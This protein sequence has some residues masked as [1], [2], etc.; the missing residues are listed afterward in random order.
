MFGLRT[1]CSCE[2]MQ[3]CDPIRRDAPTVFRDRQSIGQGPAQRPSG[4]RRL[5][6]IIPTIN[7]EGTIGHTLERVRCGRV[8]EVIVVDGRST[9]RTREIARAHGATVVESSPGRGRQLAAG[10]TIATGDTLLFLHADT[11]L[12]SGFDDHVF[13]A[14]EKRGVCAAAFRLL[15][16]GEGQ[17][18]RLIDRMVNF[19]SSV[20]QMPYGDQ[21]IFVRANALRE[22][23]GFPDLPVMEDYVLIRR[24][25][26]I[27]RIE[28][29]P[30]TVVTSARRWI[31]QGVLR[32]T[33]FNQVCIAA[34]WLGVSPAR[35]ARWR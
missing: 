17:C 29:V 5:S 1:D 33:L 24:L 14:L 16:D 35:I 26:R 15:I 19:R 9:D 7:E 21:A 20:R 30:A 13:R 12:P 3:T 2:M 34:Y 10:A 8:W 11:S 32:T 23:G 27:G 22:A 25:R 31:E 18:F 6:V 28:I 4:L